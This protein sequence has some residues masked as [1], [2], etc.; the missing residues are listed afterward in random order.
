MASRNRTRSLLIV[1]IAVVSVGFGVVTPAGATFASDELASDELASDDLESDDIRS[2]GLSVEVD[3]A[4]LTD[5]GSPELECVPVLPG[6]GAEL[7]SA[8]GWSVGMLT[9]GGLLAGANRISERNSRRSATV[10]GRS[11]APG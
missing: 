5:C 11:P 6:T 1:A 7:S 8:I 10:G 4:P 9:L 2:G 3:I